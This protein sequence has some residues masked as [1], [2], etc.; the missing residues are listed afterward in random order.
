MEDVGVSA[1]ALPCCGPWDHDGSRAGKPPGG[2]DPMGIM[3]SERRRAL[4]VALSFLLMSSANLG[5]RSRTSLKLS[6]ESSSS[7]DSS[8]SPTMVAVRPCPRGA[9]MNQDN[10]LEFDSRLIARLCVRVRLGAH[11]GIRSDVRN[12]HCATM[13][14]A[15][16]HD[17]SAQPCSEVACWHNLN[18]VVE[19]NLEW[20]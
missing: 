10:R 11:H 1:P 16:M 14:Q 17:D 9:A 20:T 4:H 5:K 3:S 15:S 19:N 12:Q 2:E 6:F 8:L 7:S 13:Y 18:F